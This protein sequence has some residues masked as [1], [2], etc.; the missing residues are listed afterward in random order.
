LKKRGETLAEVFARLPMTEINDDK[1]HIVEDKNDFLSNYLV[2]A[3]L[4][5]DG[6]LED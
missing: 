4:E 3:N 1:E 2:D 5:I 6:D